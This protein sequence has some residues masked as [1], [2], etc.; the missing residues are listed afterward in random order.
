[1]VK[2][3]RKQMEEKLKMVM[4]FMKVPEEK[5]DRDDYESRQ[6]TKNS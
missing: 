6:K 5:D 2:L 1:M 3:N 4:E